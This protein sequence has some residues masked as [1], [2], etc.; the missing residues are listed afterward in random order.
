ST[1]VDGVELGGSIEGGYKI[2]LTDTLSVTPS[3][4]MFY[5]QISYDETTDNYG[6]NIEYGDLKQI[7]LEAG[8]KFSHA[9]FTGDGFY[10]LYVKPSMVQT[11]VNGDEV[12]IT[13]LNKVDAVE[14]Q[15]L[16]RIELGGNYG[17]NENWSA[18]GW[19]NYTFGSSY[20]ATSLGLGVNYSW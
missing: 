8:V 15:T 9:K 19:A 20:K 7:E 12:N 3:L 6:K 18:Y 2:A 4:G 5:N 14:D 1:S 13:G 10:S 11:I 16:G 17:F